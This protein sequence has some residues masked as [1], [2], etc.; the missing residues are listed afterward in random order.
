MKGPPDTIGQ[1]GRIT[2]L[3]HTGPPASAVDLARR[4][5]SAEEY[6]CATIPFG[7][8]K[9]D[10]F[11]RE[12]LEEPIYWAIGAAKYLKATGQDVPLA[13]FQLSCEVEAARE[14][15]NEYRDQFFDPDC[16]ETLSDFEARRKRSH[17]WF[18]LE[19]KGALVRFLARL[20]GHDPSPRRARASL[21]CK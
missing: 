15:R 18:C 13:L 5:C 4:Y 21:K 12:D 14:A 16:Q 10:L 11:T 2:L 17:R 19:K 3:N 20:N 8:V 7:L 6:L 9:E 1:V